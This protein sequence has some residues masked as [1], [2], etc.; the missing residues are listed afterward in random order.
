MIAIQMTDRIEDSSVMKNRFHW[1][2]KHLTK[3]GRFDKS[4]N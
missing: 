3:K 1:I 4:D 2:D